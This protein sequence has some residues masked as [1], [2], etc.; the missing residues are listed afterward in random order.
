MIC[1][2]HVLAMSMYQFFSCLP[3]HDSTAQVPTDHSSRPEISPG[4]NSE[5]TNGR[6][7]KM[8]VVQRV[9]GVALYRSLD[10]FFLEDPIVSK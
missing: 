7:P 10:A 8:E 1:C 3:P 2:H 9:M 6:F 5:S 4:R